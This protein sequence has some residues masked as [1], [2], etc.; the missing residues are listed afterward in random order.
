VS[1][2]Y[3]K[4][5]QRLTYEAA[6]AFY[7]Q[8]LQTQPDSH[9]WAGRAFALLKLGRYEDALDSYDQALQ[10]R[11]DETSWCNRGEALYYQGACEDALDSY[12]RALEIEPDFEAALY[13]KACVQL[14]QGEVKRALESLQQAIALSPE[15]YRTL[16]RTDPR[17]APLHLYPQFHRLLEEERL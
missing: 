12:D 6:I 5:E 11:S 4:P 15:E 13:G 7:D 2:S 1:P 8:T 9:A 10:L 17:L 14:L 3:L 16:A